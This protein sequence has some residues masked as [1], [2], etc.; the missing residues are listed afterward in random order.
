MT[1]TVPETVVW[2]SARFCHQPDAAAGGAIVTQR[3]RRSGYCDQ[4]HDNAGADGARWREGKA[5]WPAVYEAENRGQDLKLDAVLPR[6][7]G[8]V[9]G[10]GKPPV[11]VGTGRS[12]DHIL[13]QGG[14][15]NLQAG[16]A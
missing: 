1:C 2:A 13:T 15:L 14:E 7:P 4:S 11:G 9:D 8:M 3:W 10:S 6:A 5:N 16:T 12:F